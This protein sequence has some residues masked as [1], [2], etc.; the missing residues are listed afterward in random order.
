MIKKLKTAFI[1]SLI[2]MLA[3]VGF[4]QSV[5]A[6]MIG[7]DQ[8]LSA[9]MAQKNQ[10]RITAALERPDVIAQLERFGVSKEDAQS[11]VAALTDAEAAQLAGQIDTLPAGGD[12][13]WG[14]VVF[15]F[16][17]LVVSDLLGLTRIFPFTQTR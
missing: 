3:F 9:E 10:E 17:L 8:V 12:S 7:T 6:T 15:V 2:A 4:S 5:H 16:L 1:S 11:R 13:F 14:A